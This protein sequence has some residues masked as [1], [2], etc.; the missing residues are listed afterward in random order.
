MFLE[1]VLCRGLECPAPSSSRPLQR[2]RRQQG[3][4]CNLK[5]LHVWRRNNRLLYAIH[6]SEGK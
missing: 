5:E 2:I 6:P 3:V 1:I 4:L